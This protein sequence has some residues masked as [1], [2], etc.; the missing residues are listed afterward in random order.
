MAAYLFESIERRLTPRMIRQVSVFLDE[1]PSGTRK[2]VAIALPALLAG[3]TERASSARGAETLLNV[4]H[5]VGLGLD[6]DELSRGGGSYDDL[7][8]AGRSVLA[9]ILGGRSSAVVA[10]MASESDLRLSSAADVLEMLALVV[11]AVIGREVAPPGLDE[12]GLMVLLSE[13]RH[14]DVSRGLS[15]GLSL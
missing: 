2:A 11:I 13:Q 4:I 8:R 14:H 9:T 10:Q 3:L 6:L 1:R 12:A 5:R 15:V 7:N